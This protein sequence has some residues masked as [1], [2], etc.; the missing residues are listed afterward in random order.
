MNTKKKRNI[1]TTRPW[2][3]GQRTPTSL[4]VAHVAKTMSPQARR[5][6]VEAATKVRRRMTPVERTMH[7]I[8]V[9]MSYLYAGLFPRQ[10]DKWYRSA[11]PAIKTFLETHHVEARAAV[12]RN[13]T[14]YGLPV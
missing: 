9:C 5:R 11:S 2:S 1:A 10:L 3:C 8:C 12:E 4:H 7:E 6:F 14:M 13:P